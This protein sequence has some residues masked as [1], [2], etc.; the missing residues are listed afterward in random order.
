MFIS[1]ADGRFSFL[2]VTFFFKGLSSGISFSLWWWT[3]RE[4]VINRMFVLT[5]HH[6]IIFNIALII[7]IISYMDIV[8]RLPI[9]IKVGEPLNQTVFPSEM[10]NMGRIWWMF[11]GY[12][13]SNSLSIWNEDGDWRYLRNMR[14]GY[15]R[16]LRNIWY[17]LFLSFKGWWKWMHVR[18]WTGS[19]AL[20][21]VPHKKRHLSLCKAWFHNKQGVFLW[22]DPK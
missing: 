5:H 18:I 3:E 7:V 10:S 6:H 22:L 11:K 12:L 14:K 16:D 20:T 21:F 8:Q 13:I 15:W 17:E 4:K 2:K 1:T 9:W 19:E